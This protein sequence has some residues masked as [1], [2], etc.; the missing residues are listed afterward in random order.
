MRLTLSAIALA[1]ALT[2]PSTASAQCYQ[3]CAAV[4]GFFGG[5]FTGA[6][7]APRTVIVTQPQPVYVQPVYVQPNYGMATSNGC[8]QQLVGYDQYARPVMQFICR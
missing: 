6:A 7:L 8:V 1:A 3:G 2:A 4:L 5:L